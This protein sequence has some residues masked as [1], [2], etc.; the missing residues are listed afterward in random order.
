MLRSAPAASATTTTRS[1]VSPVAAA[2]GAGVAR[3]GGGLVGVLGGPCRG[4][5]RCVT[6]RGSAPGVTTIRTGG[7]DVDGRG[8]GGS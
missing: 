4:G 8:S 3:G 2:I 5:G 1:T 7:G 6:L